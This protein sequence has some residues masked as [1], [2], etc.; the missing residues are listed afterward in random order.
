MSFNSHFAGDTACDCPYEDLPLD[1]QSHIFEG[2][3][4]KHYFAMVSRVA[5]RAIYGVPSESCRPSHLPSEVIDFDK[6]D[7]DSDAT[8]DPEMSSSSGLTQR[9]QVPRQIPLL[10]KP[11]VSPVNT[12][13]KNDTFLSFL[14]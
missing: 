14:K 12:Y 8:L 5:E 13:G 4:A 9:A 6:P 7:D 3:E 10:L 1:V 2:L 11:T